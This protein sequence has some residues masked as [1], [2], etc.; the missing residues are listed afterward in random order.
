MVVLLRLLQILFQKHQGLQ[1]VGVPPAAAPLPYILA[2]MFVLAQPAKEGGERRPVPAT[3]AIALT[4]LFEERHPQK[5]EGAAAL[6][7]TIARPTKERRPWKFA[8][9]LGKT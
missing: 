8:P 9:A 4:Q 2:V 3:L 1:P 5:F 6:T 7:V